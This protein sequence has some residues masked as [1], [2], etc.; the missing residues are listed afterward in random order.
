M[1]RPGTK[2]G[3]RGF[4]LLEVL[5]V[6][7]LI[8]GLMTVVFGQIQLVQKRYKTEE[9]KLDITQ[10]SRAFLEQIVRDLHQAGYPNSRM[11]MDGVLASPVQNDSRN[12]VGLVKFSYTELQFEGDVD[13]DGQVESVRYTLQADGGGNCP[14]TISRSQVLK[15]NSTAPMSQPLNY[16]IAL[17]NV[18]NSGGAGGSGANGSLPLRGTSMI[19]GAGGMTSVANDTLYAAYKPAYV[20]AAFDAAG[21]LVAPTDIAT[22]PV[23]LASIRT[24]Q[25]TLNVLAPSSGADIQTRQRPASAMTATARI[26]NR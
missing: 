6:T 3:R 7:A 8:V 11:Y 12:A 9:A 15:L 5:V 2:R 26:M 23:A 19:N 24:I 17:E 21:D 14:C 25:I 18:V 22:N 20:F 1:M 16:A 10:E 13:G 4:S